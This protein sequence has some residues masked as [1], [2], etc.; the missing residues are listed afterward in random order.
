[1][2]NMRM[3]EIRNRYGSKGTKNMALN[4]G[5]KPDYNVTKCASPNNVV[6]FELTLFSNNDQNNRA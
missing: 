1:M 3:K 4:A 2:N 6:F 5:I